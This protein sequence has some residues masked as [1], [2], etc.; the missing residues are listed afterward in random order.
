MFAKFVKLEKKDAVPK[1]MEFLEGLS[2]TTIEL[3]A[4][5]EEE[6]SSKG[7]KRRRES[8]QEKDANEDEPEEDTAKGVSERSAEKMS[9]LNLSDDEL[10]EAAGEIIREV[11][12]STVD[13][14]DVMER[15]G[16]RFGT[17]FTPKKMHIRT[18]FGF[19]F[20]KALAYM[21]IVSW[22][23]DY[24]RIGPLNSETD[25]AACMTWLNCMTYLEFIPF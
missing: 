15:L 1:L 2:G 4:E 9:E 21:M 8:V 22:N 25:L 6:Q 11:G 20:T 12:V 5:E 17:D 23:D 19:Q 16:K 13:F 7:K 3:R 10:C 18:M 24:F 14:T